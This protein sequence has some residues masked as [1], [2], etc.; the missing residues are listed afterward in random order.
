[1]SW[2][3]DSWSE[4]VARAGATRRTRAEIV[5]EDPKALADRASPWL[6]AEHVVAITTNG[7]VLDRAM[8]SVEI[9]FAQLYHVEP[10]DP[11]PSLAL[12]WIDRG[13]SYSCVVSPP[14]MGADRFAQSVEQIVELCATRV[15]RAAHRGWLDAPIIAWERI[16]ALP[17]ERDDGPVDRG[18]RVAP[19]APEPILATRTIEGSAP[20]L[21]TWVWARF[22]KTRR[23]EPRQIVLTP[24]FLYA[25]SREGL[26]YRVPI[27]TL[28]ARRT[29]PA[30][31][32][33]YVFGRNT[34]LLVPFAAECPLCVVLDAK[35]A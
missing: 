20:R 9:A 27:E 1:M 26:R 11:W 28:R 30:G 24:I 21:M 13:A 8:H 32:T 3:G 7:L 25:K 19:R 18:Y 4:I 29:T 12:G 17:D 2:R 10:V 6:L 34:E 33:V 5:R 15:S 22:A 35:V 14:L 16:E 23:I 31:D